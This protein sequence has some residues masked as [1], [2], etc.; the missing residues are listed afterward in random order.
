MEKS[1]SEITSQ[2]Q[3]LLH[4]K[5]LDDVHNR[6]EHELKVARQEGFAVG[7]WVGLVMGVFIMVIFFCVL[8]YTASAQDFELDVVRVPGERTMSQERIISTVM[9]AQQYFAKS[10]VVFRVEFLSEEYSVCAQYR[11]YLTIDK[12]LE[13]YRRV[14]IAKHGFEP[15]KKLLVYYATE[16]LIDVGTNTS[17]PGGMAEI[18]GQ[19]SM[20]SATEFMLPDNS[21]MI[22]TSGVIFAHEVYHMMCARHRKKRRNL[23]SPYLGKRTVRFIEAGGNLKV[24]PGTRRQVKK[25][26]AKTREL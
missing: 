23:M 17:M 20:G 21:P 13:C 26:Y 22:R 10:G 16:P 4:E 6:R 7:I 9:E 11:S 14:Y 3:N 8:A 12:E 19:F 25:W 24:M 5:C 1:L 2:F 18:C 15:R